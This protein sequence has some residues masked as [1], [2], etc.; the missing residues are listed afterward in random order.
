MTTSPAAIDSPMRLHVSDFGPVA[1]AEI[2][3]RPL[4]VFVGPGNTG[5]SYVASLLHSL[6]TVFSGTPVDLPSQLLEL[7]GNQ[8]R[9]AY[10]F[11]SRQGAGKKLA[12]RN[13]EAVMLWA[14]GLPNGAGFDKLPASVASAVRE[15]LAAAG[16]TS[17]TVFASISRHVPAISLPDMIRRPGS[18]ASIVASKQFGSSPDLFEFRMR[19]SEEE[20]T[21][22][23]VFPSKASL[24]VSREQTFGWDRTAAEIARHLNSDNRALTAAR[25]VSETAGNVFA[26]IANPFHRRSHYLPASRTGLMVAARMRPSEGSALS[27]I[28]ADFISRM[29]PDSLAE[30]P[31]TDLAGIADEIGQSI[32]GGRISVENSRNGKPDF[33]FYSNNRNRIPLTSASSAAREIAPLVLCLRHL[34]DT[35]DAIIIEQP[36]A[37]L[38]PE[39]QVQLARHLASLVNSGV[40]VIVT[41]HSEWMAEAFTNIV[42]VSDLEPDRR[43]GLPSGAYALKPSEVGVW[44]F[45]PKRRPRGSVVKEL[46]LI[47][48][49]Q[50]YADDY[51]DVMTALYDEWVEAT[52][53]KETVESAA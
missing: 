6:H 21:F 38:H 1:D 5:K 27:G 16:H 8:A 52:R 25:I 51:S 18:S 14:E 10:P 43:A 28:Q 31:G 30:M 40:R 12:K 26:G 50:D 44:R 2:D 11:S 17:E 7:L 34:A 19:I 4:T 15:E 23:A 24:H 22:A 29:N 53:R 35:S 47:G 36:E 39:Q 37:H 3:L 48:S 41:T 32:A 13:R 45:V 46:R 9:H 20:Q 49:Q 33:F 42:H